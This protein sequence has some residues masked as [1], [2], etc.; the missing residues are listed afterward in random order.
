MPLYE[1]S[2]SDSQF[3]FGCLLS[4]ILA[5]GNTFCLLQPALHFSRSL[6]SIPLFWYHPPKNE[7][8]SKTIY[9]KATKAFEIRQ[10]RTDLNMTA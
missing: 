8:N 3:K 2:N 7:Y 1:E 10:P 4:A 5:I 6:W 9:T